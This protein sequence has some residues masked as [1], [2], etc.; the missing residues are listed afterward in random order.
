MPQA[1]VNQYERAF[2][3]WP[4]LAATAAKRSTIIYADL[5]DSLH[6]HPRPIRYVLSV[7]QEPKPCS[8]N[9]ASMRSTKAS[10]SSRLRGFGEVGHDLGIAVHRR[11]RRPVPLEPAAQ[12]QP[13]GADRQAAHSLDPR[14]RTAPRSSKASPGAH[15]ISQRFPS[16]SAM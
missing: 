5:S 13:L 12:H 16:G 1:C 11:E 8:S 15:P 9:P 3:A 2:R 4:L 7:I 10:L 14:R 6:I